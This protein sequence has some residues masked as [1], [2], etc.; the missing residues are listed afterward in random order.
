MLLDLLQAAMFATTTNS[1]GVSGWKFCIVG[2]E[3]LDSRDFYKGVSF[4]RC[5]CHGLR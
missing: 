2:T 5:S 3:I 4:S 1:A